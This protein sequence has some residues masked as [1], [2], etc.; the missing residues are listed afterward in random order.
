MSFKI[1]SLRSNLW[2][3]IPKQGQTWLKSAKN[4]ESDL[5]QDLAF[6][7][8]MFVLSLNK[9]PYKYQLCSKQ[10]ENITEENFIYFCHSWKASKIFSRMFWVFNQIFFLLLP[11]LSN[12]L[13]EADPHRMLIYLELVPSISFIPKQTNTHSL[14]SK[15]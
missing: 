4:Q 9:M 7:Q 12:W 10:F 2:N 1:S 5:I 15:K 14:R 13:S 11:F 6:D 3:G 8:R